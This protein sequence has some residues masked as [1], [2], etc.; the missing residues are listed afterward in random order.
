M[1]L[2]NTRKLQTAR[3][4]RLSNYTVIILA[5]IVFIFLWITTDTFMQSNNIYS[6]VYSVSF[7][8][9]ASLGFTCLMIMGE[10]DLSVGSMY[11]F[12]G[13]FIGVTM[14]N[15][16]QLEVSVIVSILICIGVGLGIG[17]IV[18][19]FRLNSMMVTLGFL[20]I[21]QGFANMA[22]RAVSKAYHASYREFAKPELFGLNYTIIIMIIAVVVLEIFLH[23]S[24]L[25]KKM[26][27]VGQNIDTARI[28]G[29]KAD[30][31]KMLT[32]MFSSLCAGV[33]G[34]LAGARIG[35]PQIETGNGLEFTMVTA[36]VLG[37]ASLFGGKGSILKT[38]I[39][40]FFLQMVT[41]GMIIHEI[42]PVAQQ[43]VI[44]AI[45]IVAV[46]L[47]TRFNRDAS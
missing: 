5:V 3:K 8:A 39:G 11:G 44:G 22:V 18:T 36:C 27:I 47:D 16:W 13:A 9:I 30:R 32:F 38:V 6:I 41:N 26:F 45:L 21:F 29:I 31:I 19:K 33:G 12:A 34:I 43:C 23:R 2:Q 7:Y 46:F 4:F 1:E 15:G 42:E 10:I 20:Y 28:N 14:R 37:G 25:F 24:A 40:L 17:F 35:S